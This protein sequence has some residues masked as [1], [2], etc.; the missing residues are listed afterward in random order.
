MLQNMT[1]AAAVQLAKTV[2]G[3][4]SFILSSKLW[5]YFVKKSVYSEPI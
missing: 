2:S 4:H 5:N 3:A 1:S